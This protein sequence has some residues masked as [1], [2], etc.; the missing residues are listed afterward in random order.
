M[1]SPTIPPTHAPAPVPMERFYAVLADIGDLVASMPQP[2]A[3]YD[4]VVDIFERQV[5]ALL[6]LV[7]EIDHA[8]GVM[9][10]RA[11]SRVPAGEEDIYPDSV[12]LAI[13]RPLFWEGRID[14]EPDIVGAPG[15]EALRPGYARHG[16]RSSAA[17]PVRCFGEI[18]AALILRSN[19]SEF[20]T[21]ELLQLLERAAL[22]ISHALEGDA[23]LA[24]LDQ[25]LLAAERSQR[26]LQLLSETLKVATH[27]G[28]EDALLREACRVVVDVGAYPVCW[29]GLLANDPAQTLELR[30]H[31]GRGAE[32]YR[33]LR[34]DLADPEV[35]SSMS[36]MVI[37]SGEPVMKLTREDD[38]QTG[39]S[40]ARRLGLGALLGLP[41]RLRGQVAGV[42]V[43]GA[44]AEDAFSG[45][46]TRVFEEIARELSL[47]LEQLRARKAQD[48]AEQQLKLNLRRFQAILDSRYAGVLVMDMTDR[49]QFCNATLC[50]MFDLSEE[51]GQL[52][53]LSATQLDE[54]V[55][56]AYADPER[57]L[58]RISAIIE[59]AEPVET[60]E[61]AISRG[62]TYLRSFA[63]LML[64][65][66]PSGRVWHLIDI[67]ERKAQE[68]EV[69]RLAYYDP[70]TA[71]PNRRLFLELLERSLGQAQR[72]RALLAV[73]VI[74]LD[75]FKHVNDQ[76]GHATGNEVL[77]EIA[78]R[79]GN[80]LD[81][82]DVVG[83]LGSD[84]F[85]ILLVGLGSAQE[86]HLASARILEAIRAPLSWKGEVLHLSAS[87]GLT[88]YPQD[89]VDAET[90]VRHA[91]L[92]MFV[93]KG[94]GRDHDQ[95]YSAAIEL[96]EME[97]RSMKA[98]V[99]G[100]L[101]DGSLV[102][103]F[104]PIVAID[105][106]SAVSRVIGVEALLRLRDD[107]IGLLPPVRFHH[108]L[109]D[110]RLA[111]PIGRHV[112]DAALRASAA[113]LAR[114]IR[115]P[116]AVN[117]STRHLMHPDFLEDIDQALAAHPTLDGA[118][119]GIEITETGPLL[120][121][122]RAR[123]VI[124]ECRAR[125]V[126]VSL[127][128]FGTGSASL[129]HVQQMDVTTLKIDQSFVRD[130]L[131][132]PRN[133]AIATGILT[134]ALL[135]GITVI[136]E[137]IESEAQGE[138]LISLGCRRLQGYAIAEPMPA[139][140]IPAWLASW[141]PPDS[142]RSGAPTVQSATGGEWDRIDGG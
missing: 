110:T 8:A 70:V 81:D 7:G 12:P 77:N 71:L 125:R 104:Q 116:V 59:R 54:R 134:T 118:M 38:E 52:I 141:M 10:R 67:T 102:L 69:E 65:G 57:E 55:R 13:A 15:R 36:A 62:R 3:L 44:E 115:L 39:V 11:P 132:D 107:T 126:N 6:V 111:R 96:A 9:R 87:V 53:G 89:N 73:G 19:A 35:S 112:L 16:I 127:D 121:P 23:Q 97:Q 131:V 106:R 93:A 33:S 47:G 124:D 137:G 75:D 108:A 85:A 138:T 43:I 79:I 119:L 109:D 48:L 34:L 4:G 76:L 128:D 94:Q 30:A 27:A 113:W 88:L 98:R 22:S 123:L 117:I 99:A 86:M 92:A 103:L 61:I 58:N 28:T 100:A 41:L 120:D 135:L 136:A 20:F 17:V 46:Q 68:A 24:R 72:H 14:V 95:L 80:A 83:R 142:W 64:E 122:A 66:R 1:T 91:D 139:E 25:A 50:R 90:L 45:A 101:D 82:G 63:P 31:A 51:P 105:V 32:T 5:G 60:E 78:R 114:G 40:H 21:P 140:E 56:M 133:I 18:R 130:I 42:I 26:A 129:S 49:V 37:R 29:M 74:D 2:Q 84:E